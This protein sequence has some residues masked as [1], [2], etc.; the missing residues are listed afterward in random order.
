MQILKNGSGPMAQKYD[1]VEVKLVIGSN[2]S[3]RIDR[4]SLD[5]TLGSSELADII[6]SSV[7]A[8]QKGK[9]VL[10]T[11]WIWRWIMLIIKMIPEWKFKAMSI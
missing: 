4:R 9:N 7:T 8:Q 3:Q 6:D 1:G 10:Y 5:F 2:A 11:K